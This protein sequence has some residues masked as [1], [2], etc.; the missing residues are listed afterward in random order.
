M[1]KEISWDR[2]KTIF[3][4]GNEGT[5]KGLYKNYEGNIFAKTGTLSNHVGLSGYLITK[6]GEE[7][8]F[9]VLVNHY[10][11]SASNIRKSIEKMITQIIEEY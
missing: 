10:T 8:I 11:T 9:S 2:I 7:L 5:L 1:K 6:K 3:A 4:T